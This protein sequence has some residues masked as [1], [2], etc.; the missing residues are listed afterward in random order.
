MDMSRF[1]DLEAM[2]VEEYDSEEYVPPT[3]PA[4]G[5]VAR[6]RA[7]EAAE[8]HFNDS[9]AAGLLLLG[10]PDTSPQAE[11]EDQAARAEEIQNTEKPQDE[12]KQIRRVCFT[13]NNY[14]LDPDGAPTLYALMRSEAR[15]T[16]VVCG[17]ERGAQGTPH[18]QGYFEV[19]SSRGHSIAAMQ[20]WPCFRGHGVSMR[21]ARGT[22]EQNIAYCTKEDAEALKYGP[23]SQTVD[24][25]GQG[26]RNDWHRVRELARQGVE[27]KIFCDEVPHLALPHI[28]KISRWRSAYSTQ[29]REWKTRP[30]IYYG[31]TRAGKSTRARKLAGSGAYY[32]SD[33]EKW[34]PGYN[35]EKTVIIDEMHGGY[36]QWQHLLKVFEEGPFRVQVKGGDVEFLAETVIMTTNTHPALWYKDHPWDDSN[37]FRARIEEFGEL[38]VFG[39]REKFE[40][41]WV[42]PEPVRDL[43]LK[44][45]KGSLPTVLYDSIKYRADNQEERERLVYEMSVRRRARLQGGKKKRKL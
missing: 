30:I 20:K 19:A 15:I 38:W 9:E 5:E 32:K 10:S 11:A 23:F 18:L 1:L 42:Y 35:G 13:V 41:N 8:V 33:A 24:R 29:K 2:E 27:D 44:D 26:K 37:A 31:P 12:R 7:D 34:W 36:F 14:E 21:T 3:Q 22:S 6:E 40:G 4:S 25:K 17:R 39:S 45:P 16:S 43:E 28:N